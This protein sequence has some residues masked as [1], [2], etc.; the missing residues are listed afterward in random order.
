MMAGLGFAVENRVHT[1]TSACLTQEAALFT[2]VYMS[3]ASSQSDAAVVGSCAEGGPNIA[4]VG[5]DFQKS[6]LE[7]LY[8]LFFPCT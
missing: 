4:D 3:I 7:L 5:L 1:S 2:Y 6:V 8:L